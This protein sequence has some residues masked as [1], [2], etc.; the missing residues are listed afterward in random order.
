MGQSEDSDATLSDL[1]ENYDR[2][3]TY[4]IG[5]VFALRDE[6]LESIGKTDSQLALI[7]LD[8]ESPEASPQAP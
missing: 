8:Y 1:V 2:D 3:A 7:K 5:Y 6:P 4:N